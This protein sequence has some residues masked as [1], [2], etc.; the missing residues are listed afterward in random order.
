M[1]RSLSKGI[2]IFLVLILIF[3]FIGFSYCLKICSL[4]VFDCLALCYEY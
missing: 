2:P 1:L 3:I 4:P